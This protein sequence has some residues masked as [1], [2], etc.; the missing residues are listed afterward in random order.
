MGAVP[1]ALVIRS[2]AEAA[3]AAPLSTHL[4]VANH[5]NSTSCRPPVQLEVADAVIKKSRFE[6]VAMLP[7]AGHTKLFHSSLKFE[8]GPMK[9]HWSFPNATLDQHL[10][11]SSK[12][13]N[14][15][16]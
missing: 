11:T 6:I 3:D 16:S 4:R 5:L 14:L 13:E 9:F 12:P 15:G 1:A 2:Q 10:A 7:M 8:E